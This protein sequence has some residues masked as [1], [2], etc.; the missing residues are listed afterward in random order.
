MTSPTERIETANNASLKE[1]QIPFGK[2]GIYEVRRLHHGDRVGKV[3]A[4]ICVITG[5]ALA[6][7]FWPAVVGIFG[8]MA[9]VTNISGALIAWPLAVKVAI[10]GMTAIGAAVSLLVLR[11]WRKGVKLELAINQL[12]IDFPRSRTVIVDGKEFKCTHDDVAQVIRDLKQELKAKIFDQEIVTLA[13]YFAGQHSGN[14]A[15]WVWNANYRETTIMAPN[16]D[17]SSTIIT[18]DI[19]GNSVIITG[20][21][22]RILHRYN[23][24]GGNVFGPSFVLKY[25]YNLTKEVLTLKF[26]DSLPLDQ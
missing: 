5:V 20:K 2:L 6:I 22:H 7:L 4:A 23:Q 19:I 18:I 1:V 26:P 10:L 16:I 17:K 21:E 12:M 13:L 25:E 3:C 8:A 14:H 24:D 15:V 11:E 9:A